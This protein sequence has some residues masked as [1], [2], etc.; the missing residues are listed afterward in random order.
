MLAL[1]TASFSLEQVSYG[2]LAPLAGHL[3]DKLGTVPVMTSGGLLTT[4]A[5]LVVG[6]S[7]L[8]PPL[9][10]ISG[11]VARWVIQVFGL[12]GVG[13]GTALSII[14]VMPF[15]KSTLE[16]F[17]DSSAAGALSSALLTGFMSMGDA[18]G[19]FAG[20]FLEVRRHHNALRAL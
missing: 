15:S 11:K 3:S 2:S 14:P 20:G 6:P 19:P 8:I 18:C 1:T 5:L 17:M 7:P 4:I 16:T 9:S 10:D 12:L 13:V